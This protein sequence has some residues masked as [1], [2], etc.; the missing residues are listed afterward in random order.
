MPRLLLLLLSFSLLASV[1]CTRVESPSAGGFDEGFRVQGVGIVSGQP[2][3]ALLGLGV[4]AQALTADAARTLAAETMTRVL[5]SLR[6]NGIKPEDIQTEQFVLRYGY[7]RA[8]ESSTTTIS[9]PFTPP[10]VLPPDTPIQACFLS[11]ILVKIRDLT[12][13]D[14]VIDGVIVAG[15][16]VVAIS[17]FRYTI[18]KP[19][20][21]VEEARQQ[22]LAD[23]RKK[24]ER[25]AQA[26]D[27]SLGRVKS[28]ST[29]VQ[30]PT[31][32]Y[33]FSTG[34][35]IPAPSTGDG[36][37]GRLEIPVQ[38]GLNDIVVIAFVQYE[39]K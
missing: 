30:I 36:G 14:A 24:A 1:A 15:A 6:A 39:T 35:A 18:E 7:G 8:C 32:G 25:Q 13:A 4:E 17:V 28:V 23:A 2:D 11:R 38:A 12:K 29:S 37:G 31:F 22:A 9:S 10:V 21:A 26:L 3:I 27:V 34:R 19:E 20:A 16:P 5:A 33:A